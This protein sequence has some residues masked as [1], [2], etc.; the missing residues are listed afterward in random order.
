MNNC[1]LLLS[2][3][4]TNLKNE[5]LKTITTKV[6]TTS[7]WNNRELFLTV[8]VSCDEYKVTCSGIMACYLRD[9]WTVTCSGIVET[10]CVPVFW[11]PSD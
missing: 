9:K 7:R 11:L 3:K 2:I 5:M 6:T 8:F 10:C 1:C 4:N